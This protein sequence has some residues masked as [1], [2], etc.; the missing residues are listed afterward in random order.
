MNATIG[1]SGAVS[2]DGREIGSV[3]QDVNGFKATAADGA[4]RTFRVQEEAVAWLK[5]VAD[6]TSSM[7][8]ARAA[9]SD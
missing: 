3:A 6:G 1:T 5:A 4:A 2:V 7:H 9:L 8:V